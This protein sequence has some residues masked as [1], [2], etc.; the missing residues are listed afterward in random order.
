MTTDGETQPTRETGFHPRTS[1]LTRDFT[2]YRGYW[3]ANTY[4]D[5]GATEDYWAC[6]E[7]VAIIDL[8]ALR[9]FEV[10]GPDAETLM[11]ATLTRDVRRL[12][13]GQVVYSAMCNEAGGMIDDGTLFRLGPDNFRWIG[14]GDDGGVWLR[15]QA[16]TLGLKVWIRPSTDLLHNVAV[17]GPKSR[18][19]LKD[20]VWTPPAQPSLEELGWFRFAVGR[21]GDF[22]GRS[23]VVSR[24]G[25]TGELGYEV[26]CHPKDAVAVW[27][28]I[29]LAG[30]PHGMAPLG[31]AAL[32]ILRIE[33]GLIFAG[34]E[35]SDQTDPFEAGIGVTVALDTKSED[36]LGRE[37]L[38]RRK[39]A[40]PQ[41]VLVGLE[42]HGDAP[43]APG[44]S[45]VS[46]PGQVGVI[47]SATRSPVLEKNIAL[48]RMDMAHGAPG[49]EVE[50][51]EV[52]PVDDRQKRLSAR[53][54]TLPFYDPEKKRV[55]G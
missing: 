16:E 43:P 1:E 54:V 5:G 37:A 2:D 4:N 31:L 13:I 8:S 11:N 44:D 27:D 48:C 15:Q 35:F 6:R 51:V 32:D 36:F 50:V 21:L 55:R 53:V 47:T 17:Q 33:A 24:T 9:K 34:S 26:W 40:G 25:T 23:V 19:V 38:I 29:W 42:L 7:R 3:L 39:A 45:V 46:G 22:D 28:A 14:G 10:L 52:G 49:T 20:V 41:R 12:A 18:E 30:K